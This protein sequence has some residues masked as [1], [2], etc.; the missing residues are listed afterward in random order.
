[1]TAARRGSASLGRGKQHGE[2]LQY[3]GIFRGLGATSEEP[4]CCKRQTSLKRLHDATHFAIGCRKWDE[5]A[6]GPSTT[7]RTYIDPQVVFATCDAP[8]KN[9]SAVE[10]RQ[11]PFDPYVH[12]RTEQRERF[13]DPGPQPRDQPFTHEVHVHL[14]DDKPQLI[15]QSKDVHARLSEEES[16][17]AA[18]LRAA[19]AGSLVP[20]SLW[21]KPMRCNPVTGGPRNVDLHD[22]GVANHLRFDRVS[23]NSSNIV[24]EANVRNPILG[25]HVPLSSFVPRGGMRT[26]VD[27][28]AE[29]NAAVPPLRSLGALRPNID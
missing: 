17:R 29:V 16:Q 18:F 4:V 22:L 14:G 8:D 20:T 10:L 15:T 24:T 25:Q 12:Y 27:L 28:V 19:G 3:S 21:P 13:M 26:T 2:E 11:C 1:M 7:H 23:A 6:R 9:L 5:G